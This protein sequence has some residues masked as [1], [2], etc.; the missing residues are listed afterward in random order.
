MSKAF[1]EG[2]R[3][4]VGKNRLAR[5]RSEKT[6]EG[7]LLHWDSGNCNTTGFGAPFHP[8]DQA[9]QR[10]KSEHS[11]C[12]LRRQGIPWEGD[13]QHVGTLETG[14][15][16]CMC[17]NSPRVSALV[18]WQCGRLPLLFVSNREVVGEI[19]IIGERTKWGPPSSSCYKQTRPCIAYGQM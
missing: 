17:S 16:R 8:H 4:G 12:G 5:I 2:W 13:L 19:F 15:L 14:K 1:S 10:K 11:V 3:V 9:R 6:L 7:T 18:Q